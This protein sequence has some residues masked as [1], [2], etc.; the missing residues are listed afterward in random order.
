MIEGG[1]TLP[2]ESYRQHYLGQPLLVF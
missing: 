2:F 1:D